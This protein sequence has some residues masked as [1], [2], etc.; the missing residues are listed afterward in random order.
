MT[1]L[2]TAEDSSTQDAMESDFI[3]SRLRQPA[4]PRTPITT[5]TATQ[6]THDQRTCTIKAH[7]Q[8]DDEQDDDTQLLSLN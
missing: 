2:T 5:T 4:R 7:D 8:D 6:P 1:W 3:I